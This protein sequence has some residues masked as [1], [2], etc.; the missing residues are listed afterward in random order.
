MDA[1]ATFEATEFV[2]DF[3][4]SRL[5]DNMPP[6]SK[7]NVQL[8]CTGSKPFKHNAD[9]VRLERGRTEY[10]A[11]PSGE[12]RRAGDDRRSCRPK[13]STPLNEYRAPVHWM[14]NFSDG[15]A[16]VVLLLLRQLAITGSNIDTDHVLDPEG[17]GEQADIDT[18]PVIP[19]PFAAD[20]ASY[21]RSIGDAQRKQATR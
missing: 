17:H 7:V 11:R 4:F 12:S 1:A 18:V 16:T 19:A 5:P 14:C 6:V 21:R 2:V 9:P 15:A 13:S 10:T 8:N 3:E 20:S